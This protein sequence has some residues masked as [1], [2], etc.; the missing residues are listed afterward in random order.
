MNADGSGMTDLTS[1]L[2]KDESPAWSHDGS[3]IA[4]MS[5]RGG[6]A[7]EIFVM[8]S[9]GTGVVPVTSGSLQAEFPSWSPDGA[10][11]AF[12]RSLHIWVTKVDGSQAWQITS[13]SVID[14]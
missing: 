1:S 13:G 5:S 7:L 9:D 6:G 11:I 4:F 3:K 2:A 12:D 14:F 10:Y 8:N